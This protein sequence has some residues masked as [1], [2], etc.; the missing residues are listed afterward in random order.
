MG[1]VGT[2]GKVS[3]SSILQTKRILQLP[4]RASLTFGRMS[5]MS[6]PHFTVDSR[7]IIND[8]NNSVPALRLRSSSVT[9]LSLGA[10]RTS[11]RDLRTSSL[12]LTSSGTLRLASRLTRPSRRLITRTVPSGLSRS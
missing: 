12:T 7:V 2:T 5:R 6:T 1:D 3:R 10:T 11:L 4:G 8:M 9:M